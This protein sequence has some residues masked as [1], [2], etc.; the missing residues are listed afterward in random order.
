[1][2]T[3]TPIDA[4]TLAERLKRGEMKLIDIREPDVRERLDALLFG[5]EGAE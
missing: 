4:A 3:L 2:T 1:M 5:R